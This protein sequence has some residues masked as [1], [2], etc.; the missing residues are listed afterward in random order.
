MALA[1]SQPVDIANIGLG[2]LGQDSITAANFQTPVTKGAREMARVYDKLRV[3]ALRRSTWRFST[4]RTVMRAVDPA[5]SFWTP[6]TYSPT[7]TYVPGY[8]TV[9]NGDWYQAQFGVAVGDI[10]NIMPTWLRYFG[11][12]V[13]DPFDTAGETQY[14][15][16]DLVVVPE[17]WLVG[18]TYAQNT[19]IARTALGQTLF[20]F[21]LQNG[22]IGNDPAASVGWWQQFAIDF[23]HQEYPA[24]PFIYTDFNGGPIVYMALLTFPPHP[25]EY[26]PPPPNPFWLEMD[27]T[28]NAVQILYPLG[29]GPTWQTETRNIFRLPYGFIR[30]VP[31]DP[32]SDLQPPVGGPAYHAES[33]ALIEGQWMV[34]AYPGPMLMRFVADVI[35]VPSMDPLFC[36]Y[37]AAFCAYQTCEAITQK[38]DKLAEAKMAMKEARGDAVTI[39][40]IETGTVD[41]DEDEYILARL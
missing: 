5:T 1:F 33:D 30:Q 38:S 15:T 29:T 35:D 19:L 2:L 31:T 22:N 24:G 32:K 26:I 23:P 7:A 11:P 27:G 10:P 20:Y 9:Y 13:L 25:Y 34:S 21:S 36:M 41:P 14:F 18:S 17:Q 6:P 16:G 12:M 8:V 37:L 39:N 4:R 40:G 28:L 3:T